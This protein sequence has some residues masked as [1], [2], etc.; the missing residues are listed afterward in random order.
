MAGPH[1]SSR[2]VPASSYCHNVYSARSFNSTSHVYLFNSLHSRDS[3][4]FSL[5]TLGLNRQFC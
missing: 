1:F 5:L 4:A 2:M 3:H